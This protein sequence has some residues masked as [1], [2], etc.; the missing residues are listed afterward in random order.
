VTAQVDR[1]LNY[2]PLA[3]EIKT[4]KGDGVNCAQ[5]AGRPGIPGDSRTD[6][7]AKSGYAMLDLRGN[8]FQVVG[9]V[10]LVEDFP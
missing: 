9:M 6:L 4:A 2:T 7:T 5:P 3:L 8:R 1:C 10:Y